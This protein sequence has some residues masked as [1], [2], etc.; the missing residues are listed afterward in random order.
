[1]YFINFFLN[2]NCF[3]FFTFL[4]VLCIQP[5]GIRAIYTFSVPISIKSLKKKRNSFIFVFTISRSSLYIWYF[6]RKQSRF[7]NG[8]SRGSLCNLFFFFC[9]D[10]KADVLRDDCGGGIRVFVLYL[11]FH[12][13]ILVMRTWELYLH[14]SIFLRLSSQTLHGGFSPGRR[15]RTK[16]DRFLHN[17][18]KKTTSIRLFSQTGW[19]FFLELDHANQRW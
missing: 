6:Q 7:F 14:L 4:G 15:T 17:K 19:S 8:T 9:Y 12:P 10:R 5:M 18:W 1:M 13:R 11:N 16:L 2:R 3:Y